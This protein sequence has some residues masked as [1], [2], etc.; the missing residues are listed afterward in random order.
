MQTRANSRCDGSVTAAAIFTLLLV[1]I[2]PARAQSSP[3]NGADSADVVGLAEIVVTAQKREQSINSVPMSIT[4]LTGDQL[5]QRGVMD[6]ADLE[7]VVPGF[8]Q[9][10]TQTGVP[11]YTLRGIGLYD[12]GFASSPTVSVYVDQVP[13]PFPLMTLGS[14]LDLERVEVLKGPQGILFGQNSTGGAINYIAAKPTSDVE[15]GGDVRF[16]RFGKVDAN[17]FVSGPLSDTLEA[18]LAIRSVQ[19]GA[20][21]NSQSRPG[22]SLGDSR[23][24]FARLLL[25]WAAS[26]RLKITVNLNGNLNQSDTQAGQFFRVVPVA[27]SNLDPALRTVPF[28]ADNDRAADWTP[29]IPFRHGDSYYQAAI[30]T[31]YEFTDTLVL[32]SITSYQRQKA[33]QVLDASATPLPLSTI[34]DYGFI[35]SFNQE[36]RVAQNVDRL[37]WI[38]G[39]NYQYD[40][41]SETA[42]YS[43]DGVSSDQPFPNIPPF[44]GLQGTT[45]QEITTAAVFGNLDYNLTNPLMVHGGVRYTDSSRHADICQTGLGTNENLN[46]AFTQIEEIFSGLGLKTTPVVPIKPGNC[47]AFSPLPDLTP[48]VNGTREEL[49][50]D[51]ISWRIGLDYKTENGALLYGNASRGYKSGI[52]SN[53]VGTTVA[54]YVPARQEKLD[55]YEIGFKAPLLDRRIQ[56]NGAGFYYSYFDKQVQTKTLDPVF[57][58][59]DIVQNVPRSRV[60]GVEAEI[61]TQLMLGLNV[62]VAASY[63]NSKVTSS[64]VAVN[65]AGD[66]GNFKGSALPYTPKFDII[67]DA[68]YTWPVGRHNAFFG[69]SLTY[70][71]ASSTTFALGGVAPPDFNLPVAAVLGVRAGLEASDQ[72]WRVTLY[73][74]NLTDRYHWNYVFNAADTRFRYAAQ[75][76]AYGVEFSIKAK[77]L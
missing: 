76:L 70:K 73:G 53:I 7:K 61:Q 9:T 20:W 10:T 72:H 36:L 15:S 42:W 1:A 26:D 22:D 74:R 32:T 13:V 12:T 29:G 67:G 66:T 52:I 57:G 23:E 2:S 21:Q 16:E 14:T 51:N 56:F 71:S 25:A 47:I 69:S 65:E 24:I 17:G 18:R 77:G 43:F 4:A 63:L 8:T 39:A 11:V 3:P 27:P 59:V 75:P 55:A 34:Y 40:S 31:D 48:Q 49:S 45:K 38:V 68:Q 35:S 50:Q 62:S 44:D 46:L 37:N 64:Y 5:S 6:T 28:A 58:P 60:V 54:E 30:H 33:H 41:A 19:G